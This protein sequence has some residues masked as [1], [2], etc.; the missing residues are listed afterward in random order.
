MLKLW[1]PNFENSLFWTLIYVKF[2]I[3]KPF[4]LFVY[5]MLYRPIFYFNKN[6]GIGINNRILISK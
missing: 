5:Y 1:K 6:Q 2:V 3:E 4:C